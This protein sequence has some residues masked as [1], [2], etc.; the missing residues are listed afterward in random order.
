MSEK[1]PVITKQTSS[2]SKDLET[3]QHGMFSVSDT[4]AVTSPII[5]GYGRFEVVCHLL[6]SCVHASITR[7]SNSKVFE[8]SDKFQRC[9][10]VREAGSRR[11]IPAEEDHDLFCQCSA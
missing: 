6:S 11:S 10:V 2:Q 9:A 3:P 5:S 8:L 7:K 4:L 1:W